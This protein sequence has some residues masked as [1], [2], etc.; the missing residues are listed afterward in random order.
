V[1]RSS[2][3]AVALAGLALGL[4]LIAFGL[5]RRHHAEAEAQ[6]GPTESIANSVAVGAGELKRGETRSHALTLDAP[7]PVIFVMFTSGGDLEL[8][9]TS[10]SGRTW[11]SHREEPGA[12]GGHG[13]NPLLGGGMAG[14][15]VER[16]ETG[17]WT[18]KVTARAVPD[19]V[20]AV[21]YVLSL[22]QD[23][24][25]HG[26]QLHSLVSEDD[27]HR[28]DPLIVR[29]SLLEAGRPVAGAKVVATVG[30]TASP[31][32][33]TATL[34][35]D[36]K[37]PDQLRGDGIYAGRIAALPASG[38]YGL[39][40]DATRTGAAPFTRSVFQ[41]FMVAETHSK[42]N[43]RFSDFTRDTDADGEP[44]DLIIKVGVTATDS[45]TVALRGDLTGDHGRVHNGYSHPT[46]VV[47]GENELELE[48]DLDD[49]QAA[50]MSGPLTLDTLWLFEE[51]DAV[52]AQLDRRVHAYRTKPYAAQALMSEPIRLDGRVASHGVDRD[53]DGRFDELIVEIGVEL[54]YPGTYDCN[55]V[56]ARGSEWL[57]QG[58]ERAEFRMGKG[59]IRLA[60]PGPCIAAAPATGE[61]AI[62]SIYLGFQAME[63]DPRPRPKYGFTSGRMVIPDAP[64]PD[65]FAP[66]ED[67][68][69][70]SSLGGSYRCE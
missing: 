37:A 12:A 43:G 18:A 70:R 9:V 59:T 60:F 17:A 69:F 47:R 30:E 44:D 57:A 55:A 19:S 3:N 58:D 42:L 27:R 4:G 45:T 67:G 24:K 41:M 48:F 64:T 11:S 20:P 6:T 32:R 16:P 56:L 61:F 21:G 35:D 50:G 63:S 22:T 66:G 31:V 49:I 28:G 54:R 23:T 52:I 68:D 62:E 10:P 13:E 7:T 38:F 34:A 39:N 25:G 14:I 36:G 1:D 5:V 46:N 53:H 33:L 51:H 26:P 15:T 8:E 40:I 2:T 65:R 29:A